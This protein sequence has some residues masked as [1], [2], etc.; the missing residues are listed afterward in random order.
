MTLARHGELTE[1]HDLRLH[2]LDTFWQRFGEHDSNTA[3]AMTHLAESLAREN[4]DPEAERVWLARALGEHRRLFGD[5][6]VRTLSLRSWLGDALRRLGHIEE[7]RHELEE[8]VRRGRRVLG[9]EHRV[10][11][12]TTINLVNVRLVE[13]HGSIDLVDEVRLQTEGVLETSRRKYGED[14]IG[15]LDVAAVLANVW[16]WLHDYDR[17]KAMQIDILTR[18]RRLLGSE[19]RR[20][21]QAENE[22]SITLGRMD[23]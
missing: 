19:N 6:D 2:V 11:I 22:L 4:Q 1:A 16:V 15:T 18:Y 13:S 3:A 21:K 17:A 12:Q 20:T 9:Q 10:T 14:D 8:T 7:A 5:D 23:P